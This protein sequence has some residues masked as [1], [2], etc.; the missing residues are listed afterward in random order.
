MPATPAPTI[1]TR[2]REGAGAGQKSTSCSTATRGLLSHAI[3][4]C[5]V[6]VVSQQLLHDT[7]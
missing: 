1:T 6:T 2:L 5:V 3:G 7:Q 4:R